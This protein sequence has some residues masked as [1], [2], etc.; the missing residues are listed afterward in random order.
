ME[1]NNRKSIRLKEY[2]YAAGNFYYITICVKDKRNDFGRIQCNKMELLD[3]GKIADLFWKEIPLHFQNA[4]L[5]EY[6]IMPNHL[7]GII[8]LNHQDVAIEG[9]RSTFQHLQKNSIP[10]IIR[11]YKASVT[12]WCNQNNF[13][14]FQ[15]QRNYYEHIIRTE[16]D[17]FRIKQYIEANPQ[18]WLE[19]ENYK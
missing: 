1:H 4:N 10:S 16:E 19:D 18:N 6:I 3:I 8:Q 9:N 12:R 13:E 15:W 11:S 5:D 14:N 7:H 2:N 17:Y